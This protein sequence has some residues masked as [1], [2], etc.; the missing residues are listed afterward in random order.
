MYINGITDLNLTTDCKLVLYA[1]DIIVYK[2]IKKHEDYQNNLDTLQASSNSSRI[3]F[4][5]QKC[6]YMVITRK[7]ST[8][9]VPPVITLVTRTRRV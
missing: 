4:N 8:S 9:L 5:P 1:D 2:P 3:M 7:R 6:K